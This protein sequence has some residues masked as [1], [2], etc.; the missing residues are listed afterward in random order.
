MKSNKIYQ[1]RS[2]S[3][4]K[5]IYQYVLK[6]FVLKTYISFSI[7]NVIFIIIYEI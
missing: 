4:L 3:V 5:N 2:G 6:I 1:S 7:K